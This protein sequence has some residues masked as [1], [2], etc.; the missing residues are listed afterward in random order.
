MQEFTYKQVE[1]GTYA[2][3]GYT[4]DEAEIVIPPYLGTITILSDKLFAGHSEITS[5]TIPDTVT[6]M[7]E[8]LFDG[9]TELRSIKLPASLERLWGLTFVRCGIEE[10]ELPDGLKTIPPFAF[11]ECRNLRKVVCGKGLKHIYDWAFSGC[12][13][14]KE[15]Q[16]GDETVVDERAFETKR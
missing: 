10:I 11:K 6:D 7:G 4:G 3:S 16:H 2:V 5:V 13:A 12:D 14:L 8:F 15:V 1:D 9:C